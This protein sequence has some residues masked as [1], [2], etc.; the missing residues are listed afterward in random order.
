[1]RA[2]DWH[3][4]TRIGQRA[5][6]IVGEH[7]VGQHCVGQHCVGQDCVGQRSMRPLDDRHSARRETCLVSHQ[8][9]VS[10]G[11]VT[12]LAAAPRSDVYRPQ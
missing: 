8:I 9:D 11:I 1:M 5:L 4:P 10:A 3:R 12:V 7:C 2:A 6:D